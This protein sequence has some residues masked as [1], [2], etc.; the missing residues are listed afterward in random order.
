IE[1]AMM[2]IKRSTIAFSCLI[3]IQ[4]AFMAPSFAQNSLHN[5]QDQDLLLTDLPEELI[6]HILSQ[7]APQSFNK[8]SAG[9]LLQLA[10]VNHQLK[11]LAEDYTLW[12]G[13]L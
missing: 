3:F 11:R 9:P 4:L 8:S 5:V 7:M 13:P 6:L 12:R 1:K 10:S 2:T